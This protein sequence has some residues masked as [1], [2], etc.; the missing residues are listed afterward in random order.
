MRISYCKLEIAIGV[1]VTSGDDGLD[2]C[3]ARGRHFTHIYHTTAKVRHQRIIKQEEQ[4]QATISAHATIPSVAAH[5][6]K[7]PKKVQKVQNTLGVS[8]L[9]KTAPLKGGYYS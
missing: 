1:V 5:K 6:W 2:D 7:R 4:G 8:I 3:V 9:L